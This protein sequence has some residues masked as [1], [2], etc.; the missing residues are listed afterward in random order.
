VEG[1]GRDLISET[2]RYLSKEGLRKT[3]KPQ[4]HLCPVRSSLE[5]KLEASPLVSTFS[6]VMLCR[7]VESNHCFSGTSFLHLQ[8]RG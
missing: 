8:G 3:L 5:Y 1:S 6:T 7:R 2:I 4:E